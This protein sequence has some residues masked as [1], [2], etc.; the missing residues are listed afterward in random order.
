VDKHWRTSE[1]SS[2]CTVVQDAPGQL[3]S[4]NPV[5]QNEQKT[6]ENKILYV[7]LIT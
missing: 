3:M 4:D 5:N 6:S 2:G 7:K 1:D